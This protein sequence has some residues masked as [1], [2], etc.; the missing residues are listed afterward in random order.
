MRLLKISL[1]LFVAFIL[2][3]PL[4]AQQGLIP[5]FPI[6]GSDIELRRLAQ[7]G[8]PLNKCGRSFAILGYESGSF[9]AWAWPLKL[10][11]N[12]EISFLLGSSTKTIP[13]RDIVRSISVTPE[14]TTLTFTYQSFT[15]TATYVTA[16][17]EPGAM[18]LF[19][20]DATEPITI[21]CG[22]L[23]VLQPMWPAGI[24]GQ[25]AYWMD[26]LKAYLI[27]EP[28]R[29]NHA[30]VGSPAAAGISYTPA[31][32]L[33]DNPSEFK[34]EIRNPDSARHSYVPVI[35]A[36]GKGSRDSVKAVYARLRDNP[37]KYYR[38]AAAHFAALRAGTLQVTT[39]A[40]DLDLAFEW[41]KVSLDNMLASNPDLGTGLIA[42]L[43]ASGTS[44][45]PGFGWYFGGDAFI[46]ALALDG[47][48]AFGTAKQALA[49]AKKWQ[50]ADGKMAHELSQA[51][52]YVDWWG[53]YPYG[54]IHGD[55]TPL[56]IIAME[57]Y[58][59]ATAD[60]SFVRMSWESLAK[61]Y[62]WCLSTDVNGDGLMDN[63]KAGLASVEYG[64]LTG[65][66]TD[67][68]LGT[69]SVQCSASMERLA[70]IAGAADYAEKAAAQLERAKK[71]FEEK[72]WDPQSW[73]YANAFNERNEH[74]KE[75][76]PWLA[77]PALWN[78]G[79]ED[80][81]QRTLAKLCGSDIST[82]WG[83][84]SISR[85]SS[86]YEPLNYNYGAVW[87]FLTG[88]VALGE[89][90]QAMIPQ[91]YKN[92][93]AVARHTFDNN[94]GCVTE[95][96]SG[97][98]NIWPQEAV[99][100]QGFSS[101]GFALPFVR[102]L[103]GLA[104]DAGRRTVEFS[105]RLPADWKQ[106]T[107][108]NYRVGE[109]SFDFLF[110]R[111]ATG[112][113]LR[114]TARNG[115]GFHFTFRPFVGAGTNVGAAHCGETVVANTGRELRH[116]T[117]LHYEITLAGDELSL[118]VPLVPTV[119]ILPPPV[120]SRTGDADHGLK[121]VAVRW[122]EK[123]IEVDVEGLAG[124]EYLLPLLNTQQI[125]SVSPGE[126]TQEGV[127]FRIDGPAPGEFAPATVGLVMK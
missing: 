40:R 126:L 10:F 84:R 94:L 13:A 112:I 71:S 33:S 46:N 52:G 106:V 3:A 63:A 49:F 110:E 75:I 27:S 92:L 47:M 72:F 70:E 81:L 79:T 83:M 15:V 48:N 113:D 32:M 56:F 122:R 107:V 5:R 76:S 82:D 9:E 21:V 58:F 105:P 98:Q 20:V 121:I 102:G 50:R 67:I 95:V 65:T 59:R 30:L 17:D 86:L 22:F 64:A 61:A 51:A 117:E 34:I 87:P 26:D 66:A 114:M 91:A 111:S 28:T 88:F 68:F 8:T 36:G 35:M 62:D 24:G 2:A 31:H 124:K 85:K 73:M 29:E 97:A 11:R 125:R 60:T 77:L 127:R 18:I 101:T 1:A 120:E 99:S 115:R 55:T 96:F 118:R 23:P 93:R 38:E 41:A 100:Q 6:A 44:G 116:A 54:Y 19:G 53:K 39:P 108:K 103:L 119:E 43:G 14:A 123:K 25:Y 45:R 37:E 42:G 7:P 104:G 89:F 57:D 12:F 16:A 74:V 4:S 78:I 109:A 80:R 90:A 69:L